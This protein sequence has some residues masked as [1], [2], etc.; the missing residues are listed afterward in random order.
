MK[1]VVVDTDPGVDDALALAMILADRALHVAAVLTVAGN[2]GIDD[3]EQNA[4]IVVSH[5]LKPETPVFRGADASL[6][7]VHQGADDYHGKDGLGGARP[8]SCERAPGTTPAALWLATAARASPGT[9]DV[10]ALGPLTNIAI[11]LALEPRLPTYVRSLTWMG[12]TI[13]GHGNVTPSAEFNAWCDPEAVHRVLHAGFAL[14]IVSWETTLAHLVPW[15]TWESWL[16]GSSARAAFFRA[17]TQRAAARDRERG[18]AGMPIPDPLAA[19]IYLDERAVLA[20]DLRHVEIV[21][22]GEARGQTI[23]DERALSA[24]SPNARIVRRIDLA[25]VDSLVRAA[26]A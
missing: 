15:P 12:G 10:I 7:G 5:S 4:R 20:S 17:I 26:L 2:V 1:T 3:V 9:I 16:A 24:R 23:V 11:A 13:A 21:L 25:R 14:T 22:A 6:I 18:F 8:E 19:A